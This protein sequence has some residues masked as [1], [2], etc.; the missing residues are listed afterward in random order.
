MLNQT[1]NFQNS[2]F[3]NSTAVD[4]NNAHVNKQTNN[5]QN[6]FFFIF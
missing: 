5:F 2:E 3:K 6:N 4:N 1:N